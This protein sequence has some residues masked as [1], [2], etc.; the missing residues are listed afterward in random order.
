MLFWRSTLPV[1]SHAVSKYEEYP[2]HHYDAGS[3]KWG[4][5]PIACYHIGWHWNVHLGTDNLLLDASIV[6]QNA[7]QECLFLCKSIFCVLGTTDLK[8][9]SASSF[10]RNW[11]VPFHVS[12]C[13]RTQDGN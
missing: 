2:D 11:V 9:K 1:L 10:S 5:N 3:C 6:T 12:R 13:Q 8:N 4:R 7:P